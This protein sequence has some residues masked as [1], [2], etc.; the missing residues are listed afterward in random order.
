MLPGDAYVLSGEAYVLSGEAYV[1]PGEAY[2][3]P[4]K[5]NVLLMK[6]I[7]T[8]ICEMPG[9]WNRCIP[10]SDD[11]ILIIIIEYKSQR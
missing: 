1:L 11:R 3:L 4:G 7:Y 2:V 8:I 5:A 9:K 6:R 10:R